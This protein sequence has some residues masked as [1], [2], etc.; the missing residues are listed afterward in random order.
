MGSSLAAN[1]G[2]S[3]RNFHRFV[4][5][6]VFRVYELMLY[7]FCSYFFTYI[8]GSKHRENFIWSGRYKASTRY[9]HCMFKICYLIF[10]LHIAPEDLCQ[11]FHI[12]RFLVVCSPYWHGRLRVKLISSQW[13]KLATV[14]VSVYQMVHHRKYP[15]S[16]Q[17]KIRLALLSAVAK[18]FVPQDSRQLM[19][20]CHYYILQFECWSLVQF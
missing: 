19:S 18:V 3:L 7:F 15:A 1:T 5:L 9:Y 10:F 11:C 8:P 12:P 13:K 16:S 2:K 14:I 4:V 20:S 17:I 6:L